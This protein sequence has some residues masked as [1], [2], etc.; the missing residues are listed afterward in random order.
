MPSQEMERLG[1]EY[2]D[3]EMARQPTYA[4]LLGDHRF[5][6]EMEDASRAS[7]DSAISALGDFSDK[8]ESIDPG[9]LTAD[10]AVARD[11]LCFEAGTNARRVQGHTRNCR[12][13][14]STPILTDGCW[15]SAI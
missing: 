1:D 3:Y 4:L 15:L 6:E 11:L 8:A 10:E 9:D 2:W 13:Q 14:P 5:D 7:E 12:H